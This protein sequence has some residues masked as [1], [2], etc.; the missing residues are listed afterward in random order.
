MSR[1]KTVANL[2]ASLI[3]VEA[4]LRALALCISANLGHRPIAQRR[5]SP[6]GSGKRRKEGRL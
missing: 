2:L 3:L 5:C 1:C 4:T 6:R